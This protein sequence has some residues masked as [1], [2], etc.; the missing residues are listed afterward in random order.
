MSAAAATTPPYSITVITETGG[1]ITPNTT[2]LNH[3]LI[4]GLAYDLR[5]HSYSEAANVYAFPAYEY[6]AC[7]G[8]SLD[9]QKARLNSVI[10]QL[11]MEARTLFS[12]YYCK[13]VL[14]KIK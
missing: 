1:K 6:N 8:L 13:S 9:E 12:R 2:T 4:H 10:K 3:K 5:N 11:E 14:D 7:S